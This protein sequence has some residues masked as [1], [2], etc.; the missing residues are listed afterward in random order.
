LRVW[1]AAGNACGAL[2][3]T[4]WEVAKK[5]L[6]APGRDTG[7]GLSLTGRLGEAGRSSAGRGTSETT[8]N[9]QAHRTNSS[10]QPPA[11]V[12]T[13]RNYG[14]LLGGKDNFAADRELAEDILRVMPVIAQI[15]RGCRL[16]LA[17]AV[18]YLA[19]EAG[20]RQFLDIGTGLPTADN[21]HELAQRI[22]PEA[23]IAYVD[24]DR[25]KSG[26]AHTLGRS[27]CLER[28]R[29][30]SLSAP[31][32]MGRWRA[33]DTLSRRPRRLLAPLASSRRKRPMTGRQSRGGLAVLTG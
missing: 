31:Q 27:G 14:Y 30:A 1:L 9:R 15:A 25:C 23:R 17:A 28:T 29:S 11:C 3:P 4:R 33:R 24:N 22:V 12:I 5:V 6:T 7:P 2:D 19:A 8:G 10:T 13:S 20:I 26:C 32:G 18:S 21:T 16:S